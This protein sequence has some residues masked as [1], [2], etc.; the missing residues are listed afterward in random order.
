MGKLVGLTG[1]SGSGK[2]TVAKIATELWDCTS[3]AMADPLKRICKEVFDFS[4]EQL[5]GPSEK[6][7]EPDK[8]YLR[9]TPG[10]EYVLGHADGSCY[11][12]PRYALQTLGTEWGR[13]CYSNVWVDLAIRRAKKLLAMVKEV[14]GKCNECGHSIT[15]KLPAYVLVFITDVRFVNEAERI[16]TEGG[17]IWKIERPSYQ[18]DIPSGVPNHPSETAIDSEAMR[19][20][21][22]RGINNAGT[23]SDLKNRVDVLVSLATDEPTNR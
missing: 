19:A 22:T 16:I 3:L 6:R 12:T 20:W 11:L 23:L 17:E 5:Y 4:D 2:D 18:G 7:N 14:P 15:E 8:R 1:H 10:G 13:N 9:T 21:V